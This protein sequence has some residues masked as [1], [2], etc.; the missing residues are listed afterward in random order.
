MVT[1]TFRP[2]VLCRRSL[3]RSPTRRSITTKAHD[4]YSVYIHWPYC[5]SK[6]TYCNFNKYVNPSQPPVERLTDALVRE[7]R[8][9]LD[10]PRFGLRDK[11]VASVYFG[12]GTPSLAS[13]KTIERILDTLQIPSDVE[14]TLEAN[15]TSAESERLQ[16]FRHVG[17]NR[18]SLGIQ[19]FNDRD[20]KIL[21][22]DHSAASAFNIINKAKRMFDK[23]T[24]DMI[25]A[26][27]GQSIRDW[28]LELKQ[29]LDLA[30]D[31]L[32]IYQLSL[33]RGTPLWKAST[34]R[35]LPPV[36]SSEEAAD[37]YD[38]TV[39][40]AAVHGFSHYEVSSYAR[41][42]QAMSKHNFSYWQGMDYLGIGPG[43]HGRLTDIQNHQRIRTFGEFHPDKYM[44]L[45]ESEGEGIRKWTPISSRDVQEELFVFGLRTRMGIPRSRFEEMTG[46]TLEQVVNQ[47]MLSLY[48]DAGLLLVDNDEDLERYV[49]EHL[50]HE[51]MRGGIRPTERGLAVMDTLLPNLLSLLEEDNKP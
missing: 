32:S 24:F 6:C 15:P 49:P 46:N 30:G 27:P 45:C 21:G 5:E 12:G 11:R 47:D 14:V 29:A 16:S 28:E 13:P 37:M 48:V 8:F 31:H 7:L 43:A 1:L 40:E 4:Q 36:A 41:A 33:E 39:E 34:K 9:Y 42:R 3:A 50:Q 25:F 17:I 51:W 20:L 26:R 44:A 38:M 22:R 23:V 2:L 35:Q 19:S 18:L 10:E